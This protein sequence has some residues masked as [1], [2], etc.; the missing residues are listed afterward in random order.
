MPPG[1]FIPISALYRYIQLCE[2]M[3]HYFT[4]LSTSCEHFS[5]AGSGR[6]HS[7]RL[8]MLTGSAFLPPAPRA[9]RLLQLPSR[10]R[11][12]TGGDKHP[13]SSP[14]TGACPTVP[15]TSLTGRGRPAP[16]PPAHGAGVHLPGSWPRRPPAGC[17]GCHR[18]VK[19]FSSLSGEPQA[20]VALERQV[21]VSMVL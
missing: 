18:S 4:K 15:T 1:H 5:W 20:A 17:R 3:V 12:D 2:L 9:Q 8:R 7:N 14:P 10:K 16:A 11:M 21:L 19:S 6:S 13:H